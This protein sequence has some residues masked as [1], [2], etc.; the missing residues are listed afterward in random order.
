MKIDV[1]N[2]AIPERT[3]DLLSSD[4][5][6]GVTLNGKNWAGGNH[7]G[8]T[9]DDSFT[10][11]R[12]KLAELES[13]DL[14]AAVIS[15]APP[16]FLHHVDA[17]AAERLSH[18]TNRGLAE[19]A[20]YDPHRFKWMA[21]APFQ[22]PERVDAVLRDAVALGASGVEVATSIVGRRLDEPEYEAFWAAVERDHLPVMIHP[23]FNEPNRGMDDFYFQNVIG[24]MLETTI[25][26][27]R[28]I[29]AGVL[30]RH[31]DVQ[32]VLVHSG[33]YYPYQ[34]GRL[35]H[36]RTVRPELANAP[37]D[38]WSYARRLYF[39]PITHDREA[40]Q[41]LVSRVGA[42]RIV[43]GTDLPFDMASPRPMDS[44]R[45]AVD[46]DTTRAIAEENPA[47][48]YGFAG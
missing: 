32:I 26:I 4:S 11:P 46:E 28:L 43:M 7:A 39:D 16:T 25:A 44:L 48:L 20:A 41:F 29:A 2:H 37:E 31:P 14:E 9:V 22:A 8:F 1:H 42:D 45:E 17:D 23:A 36:A 5:R 47:K 15:P 3:L 19:F 30:D 38:P 35:R 12:A 21:H 13:K 6:Y 33:G 10:D 27:E 40:L 18:E 24:N 34:A